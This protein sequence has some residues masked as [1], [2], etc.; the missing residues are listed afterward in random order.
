M[1]ENARF[2]A[3]TERLT[4]GKKPVFRHSQTFSLC[5]LELSGMVNSRKGMFSN[6]KRSVNF[7]KIACFSE[8]TDRSTDGK[9]LVFQCSPISY[10]TENSS[11]SRIFAGVFSVFSCIFGKVNPGK[12]VFSSVRHLVNARKISRIPKFFLHFLDWRFRVNSRKPVLSSGVRGVL[13]VFAFSVGLNIKKKGVF[14]RFLHSLPHPR[15]RSFPKFHDSQLLSTFKVWETK[16]GEDDNTFKVDFKNII[17]LECKKK[18]TF[19][20]VKGLTI[21]T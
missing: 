1:S 4:H 6:G 2:P 13:L 5:F 16:S 7:R 12:R 15:S 18:K 14:L 11:Y 3:F 17:Y 10:H 19:T 21:L 20:S 9:W 8:F